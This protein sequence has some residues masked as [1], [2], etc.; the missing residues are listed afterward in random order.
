MIESL[1]KVLELFEHIGIIF[2]ITASEC[3][4][5]WGVLSLYRLEKSTHIRA[6]LCHGKL[7]LDTIE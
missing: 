3:D 4:Q 6:A 5:K 2:L 1:I 7:E